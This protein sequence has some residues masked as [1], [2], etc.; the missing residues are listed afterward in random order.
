MRLDPSL[1]ASISRGLA[2]VRAAIASEFQERPVFGHEPD[3][4]PTAG[5]YLPHDLIQTHKMRNIIQSILLIAGMGIIVCVSAVLLWGLPGIAFAIIGIVLLYLLAPRLP[6]E[7]VMRLYRARPVGHQ[8]GHQLIRIIDILADRAELRVTPRLYVIPSATMNAFAT[9]RT[10]N[11]TIAVTEGLLRRLSLREVAAVLAHEISHIRNSDLWI[12]SLAD[13]MSRLTQIL[14]F[15]GLFLIIANLPLML[16]GQ[17]PFSWIAATLLYLSPM[18]SSLLQLALSR[19]REYDADL[20][21]A[22][23]TGDPSGLASALT[24]LEQNGGRFW[25]DFMPPG[26]RIP[27]PSVLRSHPS[28]K[29]RIKR[30]ENLEARLPPISIPEAPM[31][32]MVGYGPASLHPRYHWSWPGIWY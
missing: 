11:A 9:G 13:T 22:Q 29:E 32:T 14:C 21:G 1:Q 5:P 31:I 28:M 15:T 20:E 4:Q 8:H 25:E 23:L 19:A 26:R 3:G 30:L 7:A 24:K 6:P 17:N 16:I 12:M 18:I 2:D 10:D 27:Q